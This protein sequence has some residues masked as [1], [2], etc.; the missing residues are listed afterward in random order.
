MKLKQGLIV[1]AV[2]ACA[3]LVGVLPATAQTTTRCTDTISNT[4]IRANITVPAG[5]ACEL[6]SVT[7][8]GNITVGRDAD[9]LI[10][11]DF[12][13]EDPAPSMVNGN[14][15]V[16]A[17]GFVDVLDT[18]VNGSVRLRQAFGLLLDASQTAGTV[19]SNGSE[20]VW[21]DYSDVRSTFQVTGGPASST[22][23]YEMYLEGARMS[24][25][26]TVADTTY[27]DVYDSVLYSD[28]S[29]S[30]IGEDGTA[31]CTSEIDGHVSLVGGSGFLQ[32]GAEGPAGECGFNVMSSDVE[33]LDNNGDTQLANNV[34]RG[35]LICEGND[36]A[37]VIGANRLRGEGVGQCDPAQEVA[38]AAPMAQA[39]I[40]SDSEAPAAADRRAELEAKVAERRASAGF[41][42]PTAE[43][44]VEAEA[45]Q[46]QARAAE[47]EA[48]PAPAPPARLEG[49]ALQPRSRS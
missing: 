26:V 18:A 22:S 21:V 35:N 40:N 15:V 1:S 43:E 28:L 23:Y 42:A 32:V 29:M 2:A 27:A 16:N 20:F 25:D 6:A 8:N 3:L 36:P 31:I 19:T 12:A 38:D 37:P 33:I 11:E 49:R 9:L 4:T 48:V 10:S 45:S 14:I 7:V 13:A 17:N 24:G 34:I 39:R 5:Q 47:A 46:D 44:K 41:E 30:G